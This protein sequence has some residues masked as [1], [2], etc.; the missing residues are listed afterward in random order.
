MRQLASLECKSQ[1]NR[2][3]FQILDLERKWHLSPAGGFEG[4]Q[5]SKKVLWAKSE[6]ERGFRK[7]PVRGVD[8][9][10]VGIGCLHK[11]NQ[12]YGSGGPR[13][14]VVSLA[15]VRPTVLRS[16]PASCPMNPHLPKTNMVVC[17]VNPARETGS[18]LANQSGE[19]A[20]VVQ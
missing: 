12:A 17:D 4:S 6:R 14:M 1:E 8:S 18:Q 13:M 16:C 15:R 3:S 5:S 19:P 2:S 11:A 9:E 20:R 10:V 7:L